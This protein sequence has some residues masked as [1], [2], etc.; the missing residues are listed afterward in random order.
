MICRVLKQWLCR[1]GAPEKDEAFVVVRAVDAVFG[2]GKPDLVGFYKAYR[3][4]DTVDR[5]IGDLAVWKSLFVVGLLCPC[6]SPQLSSGWDDPLLFSHRK[7][8]TVRSDQLV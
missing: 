7:P 1:E 8:I 6:C 2:Q 4:H 3:D 5:W